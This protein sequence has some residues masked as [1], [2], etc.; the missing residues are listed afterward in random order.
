MILFDDK[1]PISCLNDIGRSKKEERCVTFKMFYL[2]CLVLRF[3]VF[4]KVA[5]YH[6][7]FENPYRNKKY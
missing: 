3:C 4:I 7:V 2:C 1:A 6:F 5:L